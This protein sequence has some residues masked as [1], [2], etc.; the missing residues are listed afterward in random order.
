MLRQRTIC[1]VGLLALAI[2]VACWRTPLA[3]TP[4][5]GTATAQGAQELQ[6]S[7]S[8]DVLIS[9]EGHEAALTSKGGRS[10]LSVYG[11]DVHVVWTSVLSK[12]RNEVYYR[13]STDGGNTWSEPMRLTNAPGRVKATAIKADGQNVYVIWV[14]T[15][16]NDNAEVYFKVSGDNGDTW[17][18]DIRLTDDDLKTALPFIT[19]VND[20]LYATW[21]DYRPQCSAS[22]SRSFDGGLTWEEIRTLSGEGIE[23]GGPNIAD[24]QGGLLN[25]VYGSQ[26]D[27]ADTLRA[28]WLSSAST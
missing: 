5:T 8:Q 13:R 6:F 9:S 23:I 27:A 17:S 21:E 15:R 18:Q 14:D 2:M 3:S 11:D 7:W 24:S 28:L 19:V 1:G 16:D 25:L 22:F 4:G 10:F 12:E 26:R 20:V